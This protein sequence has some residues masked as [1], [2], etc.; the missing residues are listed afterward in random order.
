[1]QSPSGQSQADAAVASFVKV[2]PY[3]NIMH[4]PAQIPGTNHGQSQHVHSFQLQCHLVTRNGAT[5]PATIRN[6]IKR[7]VMM[8]VFD[9]IKLVLFAVLPALAR[10]DCSS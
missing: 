4:P 5:L 10:H 2:Q 1:M 9:H 3:A 8:S 6:W 7:E